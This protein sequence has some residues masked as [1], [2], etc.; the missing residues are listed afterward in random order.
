MFKIF[1]YNMVRQN[2]ILPY[3][4]R[5]WYTATAVY[6]VPAV[7]ATPPMGARCTIFHKL[8]MVIEL[9]ET[10]KKVAIIFRSNAQFFLQGARK[11]W[12]K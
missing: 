2:L 12:P 3:L 5:K 1:Y 7:T 10:I 8:C 11:F 4:P 6:H 9:V